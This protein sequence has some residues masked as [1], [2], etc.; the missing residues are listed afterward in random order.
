MAQQLILDLPVRTSLDRGDFF[1]SEV[2]QLAL[3]RLEEPATWPNGKL[4]LV[5]P[6][7]A[8]KTHLAH[9]WAEQ[10]GA[11]LIQP[12]EL[13]RLDIGKFDGS[14]AL[15]DA[16]RIEGSAERALLHL[17]NQVAASGH[18]LLLTARRAPRY[19]KVGLPDLRSRMEATD[20]VRID[21]PD[22]AL[23]A[24]VLMKLFADR[25][26]AV[27]PS[28]I[29]WLTR[30]MDRSFADAQRIVAA[31][32]ARALAERRKVTRDLAAEVLDKCRDKGP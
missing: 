9:I 3:A 11:R 6:E 28:A 27:T 8:G 2:N 29:N 26:N 13:E 17:H 5:G 18:C 20:V 25:Q 7:S 24:A 12:P 31:I 19:W 22:E 16:D 10:E 1:V 15:D 23:L 21:A 4:V 30:H 32:D 14:A